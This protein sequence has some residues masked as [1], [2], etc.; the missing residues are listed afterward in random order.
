MIQASPNWTLSEHS[1]GVAVLTLDLPGASQN[2]LGE[3]IAEEFAALLQQLKVCSD[4]SGL[5]LTSGKSDS[6]IAGAD[7]RMLNGCDSARQAQ[8]LAERAQA[9]YGELEALPFPVV[10]AIHGACLGGGLELALACRARICSDAE[11]TRL[12]L[13]EVQLGLLPGAGGTQRL[14]RLI[15]LAAALEMALSGRK[16]RP[17]QAL[18]LGLV[19]EVVPQSILLETAIGALAGK[20]SG[21]RPRLPQRL[22]DRL[23]WGRALLFALAARQVQRRSG[24]HYPAPERIIEAMRTGLE[25][26]MAQGLKVEAERFGELVMTSESRALRELFLA[27]TEL[28]KAAGG[29]EPLPVRRVG[30]LGGGLMGGGIAYVSAIR[31]GVPVR[32]KE[33]RQEGIAHACRQAYTLLDP[34][35][36]RGRLT[37]MARD[38]QLLRITGCLDHSG[39]QQADLVI[40]AV[41]EELALKQQMVREVETHCPERTIFASNTSSLPIGGIAEAASR[42]EQVV[43][44]HY[45]SPVE[46]MPLVEVV[47]HEGTSTQTLATVVAFA[48]RQGKTPIVVRDRPGFY[49][50]RILAPYLNEAVRILLEGEPVTHI[51]KALVAFGFPVGPLTLL[52]EVG[53]DVAARI[54]P[55][56]EQQLGERFEAPDALVRLLDAQRLGRKGGRGFYR[57]QRAG[58]KKVDRTLYR[59]LGISP[60]VRQELEAIAMRCLLPMLAEAA[61]CIDEGVIRCASDGDVG[62]VFGIGFPPFLGGPYRYMDQLGAAQ[63]VGQMEQY[64][65]RYGKR[66]TPCDPLYRMA[67]EGSRFYQAGLRPQSIG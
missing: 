60:R 61:R 9:L 44:L 64:A 7:I 23:P 65:N 37:P 63:L 6:F 20:R 17:R 53:L 59:Q 54:A 4:L 2:V 57:Y 30:I 40:E 62:A 31:A 26:G 51:D 24:G 67:A 66:F 49:V 19:D 3:Q 29:G 55:V 47:P 25:Q 39:M 18:R 56:L 52:D 1:G 12:A 42:P 21:R 28:K 38:R 45:F 16:L 13:P 32:I 35:V 46:R 58:G 50:N 36:K 15:G 11:V 27:S 22:R 41:F 14:P 5:V 34:Q 33:V 10:A 8:Q 43:G 48:G